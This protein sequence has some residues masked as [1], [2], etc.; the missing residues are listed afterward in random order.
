VTAVRFPVSGFA[1]STLCAYAE[2]D[3]SGADG[4]GDPGIH[5]VVLAYRAGG[6][7]A[8]VVTPESADL[9]GEGL[10][11]LSNTEDEVAEEERKKA[12]RQRDPDRMRFARAASNGLSGLGMRIARA[13]R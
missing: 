3:W 2:E 10:T 7:K 8:L 5:A 6:G 4:L 11:D 1:E 12:P 9:V 13:F